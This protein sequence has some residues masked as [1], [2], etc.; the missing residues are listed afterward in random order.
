MSNEPATLWT[1]LKALWDVEA[2]RRLL[3]TKL[4]TAEW[5]ERE[6]RIPDEELPERFPCAKQNRQESD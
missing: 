5:D 6:G 1:R 2:R 4:H 3:A